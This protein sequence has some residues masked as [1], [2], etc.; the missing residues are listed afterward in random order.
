MN[1]NI[2]DEYRNKIVSKFDKL[3][4]DEKKIKNY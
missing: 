2:D 1:S 4:N 3:I